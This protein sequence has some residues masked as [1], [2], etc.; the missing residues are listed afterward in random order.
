MGRKVGAIVNKGVSSLGEGINAR[1]F[2]QYEAQ[3]RTQYGVLR[4]RSNQPD[5]SLDVDLTLPSKGVTALFGPS[6][7]GKTTLL[8]CVAGLARAEQGCLSVNG[9]TWQSDRLFLPTHKRPLG[10]VFQESSLFPH[11]TAQGN[12]NYAVNRASVANANV[13]YDRVIAVMGI[14]SI[15][16]R[17]P[18]QL[19]GGE[20]QRVAIARALLIQPQILLM[21]EPLARLDMERKQEI[22]PYLE[23]LRT[24]FDIPILYVSHSMDEVARLADYVVMLETGR[25]VAQGALGEVFSRIDLSLPVGEDVGVVWHG[26]VVERNDQWHLARFASAKDV[27]WVRDAGDYVGNEV[28]LRIL[29]RDVSLTLTEHHD[30]SI[31]NRLSVRITGITQDKDEAMVLVQLQTHANCLIARLTQRSA[32]HLQLKVGQQLWAQVKS[33]AIVR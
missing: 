2:L 13:L 11:L 15:L 32:A 20:R 22:L 9:Q 26:Q 3:Y 16:S 10:Y 5:F 6:G 31:L 27:L 21:D 29:A 30:S 33:V 12:L 18:G 23:K 7:S 8:R 14:E 4:R 25:V 28:R 17:Y 24:H 19:S 1:F